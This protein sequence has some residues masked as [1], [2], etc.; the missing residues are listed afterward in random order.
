M[1]I[2]KKCKRVMNIQSGIVVSLDEKRQGNCMGGSS[3]LVDVNY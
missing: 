2:F 1:L 3:T